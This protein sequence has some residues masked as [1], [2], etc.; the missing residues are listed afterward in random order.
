L[1]D[2]DRDGDLD[3]A[4]AVGEPYYNDPGRSLL[5]LNDGLGDLGTV[6]WSTD[7]DRHSM[8]VA[9][10]DVDAD[11][12]LDLIFANQGSPHSLYSNLGGSLSAEATWE[13]ENADFGGNSLDWGDV[14][15]DG[16]LDLVVSDNMQLGGSGLVSLYCGADWSLCWQS[17]DAPDYQSA[18]S[19]EDVD[20]DGDLDLFVGAWWGPVRYYENEDGDLEASPSWVSSS[21][22]V[23]EAFAWED[24]DLSSA[25]EK[26]ETGS[27]LAQVP[28]RSRVL[29]VQG[30]VSAG[31]WVSG[32]GDFSFT[33][34]VSPVRDLAVSNWDREIGN[35]IYL[36]D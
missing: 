28:F 23:I 9:W 2:V 15:G 33:Y 14:D 19:L 32:P 30:G 27:L 34:S 7:V 4:V 31:G 8:D 1:G 5:Y 26:T 24:V 3:L 6:A 13:A 29:S 21:S 22:S 11:G 20:G 25:T 36:R 17:E 18:L 12:W 35:H 16:L 10:A